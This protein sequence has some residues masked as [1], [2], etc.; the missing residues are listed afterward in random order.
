MSLMSENFNLDWDIPEELRLELLNS[1][2]EEGARP[3][4]TIGLSDGMDDRGLIL[5]QEVSDLL[6]PPSQMKV[7]HI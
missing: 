3:I 4:K 5:V 7:E 1:G 6:L 2:V